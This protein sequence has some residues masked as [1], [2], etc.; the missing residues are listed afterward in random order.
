MAEQMTETSANVLVVDDDP[1]VR[2]SLM[3]ELSRSYRVVAA[4]SADIALKL[5]DH[6]SFD[7]IISDVR[8]PGI[9]GVELIRRVTL[10]YGEMVRI[11]LTGYSDESASQMAH[12]TAGVYKIG[13]PWGDELEIILRRGIE[14]RQRMLKIREEMTVEH[15][16]RER[17]EMAMY[18]LDK[19]ALLGTLTAS[20]GHE[21]RAPLTYLDANISWMLSAA[22]KIK[23]E[24][25]GASEGRADDATVS[26]LNEFGPVCEECRSGIKRLTEIVNGLHTYASPTKRHGNSVNLAECVARSVQIVAPKYK[27]DVRIQTSVDSSVPAIPGHEGE[28][29]QVIINLIINAIEAMDGKG[30]VALRVRQV[31]DKVVVQVEDNGPGVPPDVAP[32]IFEPFFTTK[33]EGHGTGLGLAISRGIAQR[34][35]GD[36]RFEN[37]KER[38]TVFVLELPTVTVEANHGK[39]NPP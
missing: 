34:H 8:M 27:R 31:Q 38:G 22:E 24:L 7:A 17:A 12:S 4:E 13:K 30:V 36:L 14:N 18:Q 16:A 26:I 15:R 10:A 33:P 25:A 3:D 39:S 21:I 32:R 29:S 5:L 11:L 23:L 1:S 37:G 2:E 9:D 20:V 19:M 35:G 6:E 28:L